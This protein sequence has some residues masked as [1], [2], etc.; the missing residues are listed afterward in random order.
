MRGFKAI[1]SNDLVLISDFESVRMFD[2]L[3]WSYPVKTAM[4]PLFEYRWQ[5]L[6]TFGKGFSHRA[7]LWHASDESGRIRK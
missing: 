4:L 1:L 2:E 5:R 6:L 3:C 7:S